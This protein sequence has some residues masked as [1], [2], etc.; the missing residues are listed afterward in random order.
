MG[1]L[2][3]Q[4]LQQASPALDAAAT[5]AAF[6]NALHSGQPHD[7]A[8]FFAPQ[9]RLLTADGTEV[10]GHPAISSVLSQLTMSEQRLRIRSGR[11]IVTGGVAL[12]TQFWTRSP[13]EPSTGGFES[14]TTAKLV[15]G[16]TERWQIL[17]ASPWG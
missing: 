16:H 5:A 3:D 8:A 12:A 2:R 7:A 4:T 15:L 10:G 11:T 6:A 13:R 9:G 14:S 1:T 17:I